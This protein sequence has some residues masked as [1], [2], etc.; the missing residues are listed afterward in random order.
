[1]GFTTLK[2]QKHATRIHNDLKTISSR[3]GKHFEG[4][5]EL[6]KKLEET[7]K[8]T[9]SFGR[10]A[11]SIMRTLENIKDSD[12]DG[13]DDDTDPPSAPISQYGQTS[14]GKY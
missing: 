6:R 14:P 12:S 8:I 10:D 1:M 4:I 9:D 13:D 2:I 3:F 7:I 5:V 11:R